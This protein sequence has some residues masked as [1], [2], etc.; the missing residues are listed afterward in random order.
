METFAGV[1]VTFAQSVATGVGYVSTAVV[2]L[3]ILFKGLPRFIELYTLAQESIRHSLIEEVKTL[4]KELAD[5]RAS[6]AH[7]IANLWDRIED[8][9]QIINHLVVRHNTAEVTPIGSIINRVYNT[10]EDMTD[11]LERLNAPR[12]DQSEA[13][14]GL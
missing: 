5:E 12:P 6:C 13:K 4:K 9:R 11:L 10:P 14:D 1:P 8:M 3:A 7:K 2:I